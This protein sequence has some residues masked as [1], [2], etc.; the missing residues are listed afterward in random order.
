[1]NIL[2]Y[3]AVPFV[4][5][6][7]I[8]TRKKLRLSIKIGI[9]FILIVTVIIF[10]Q[11]FSFF[12]EKSRGVNELEWYKLAPWKH[13]ILFASMVVG[14]MTN[15]LYEYIQL[16]IKA[17]E[18]KES[19]ELIPLVQVFIWE[20][21]ILPL[22]TSVLI[23]GYFWSKSGEENFSLNLILI[24]YQNGFF[25]QTILSKKGGSN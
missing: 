20:K 11:H 13:L 23:F 3:I 10:Y 14:M 19:G 17:K 24:A 21:L 5:I 9:L 12:V 25:W 1:M 6:L 16:R 7:F 18:A 22:F 15:Y 8:S 4:L 2:L